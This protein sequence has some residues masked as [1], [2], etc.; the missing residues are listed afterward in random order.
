[1]LV[2]AFGPGLIGLEE[3]LLKLDQLDKVRVEILPRQVSDDLALV[4]QL[5]AA[6][7]P[8]LHRKGLL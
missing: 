4:Q 7:F 8:K 3:T 6:L 1:M 5:P 2:P